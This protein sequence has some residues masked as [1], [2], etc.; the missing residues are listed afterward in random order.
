MPE[1]VAFREDLQVIQ[2]TSRGAVTEEDLR[3]SLEA[4][5][6]I[7]R[8][9]GIHKVLVDATGETAFP[10]AFPSYDFGTNLAR[11]DPGLQFAVVTPPGTEID[12]RFLETVVTNRGGRVKVFR[13]TD[14]ALA[15]LADDR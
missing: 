15:W 6:E 5:L 12:L 8:E 9:R 1:E 13:S 7:R 3:R 4:A 2:V 11:A 14:A 10:S